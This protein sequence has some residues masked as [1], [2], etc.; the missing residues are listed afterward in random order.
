LESDGKTPV[1]HRRVPHEGSQGRGARTRRVGCH[2]ACAGVRARQRQV[3][4]GQLTRHLVGPPGAWY[5]SHDGPDTYNH[6]G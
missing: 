3:R 5:I 6:P 2:T 1:Q 4:R